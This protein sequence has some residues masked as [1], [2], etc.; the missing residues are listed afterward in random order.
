[1]SAP[2][3]YRKGMYAAAAADVPLCLVNVLSKRRFRRRIRHST[4]KFQR[5]NSPFCCRLGFCRKCRLTSVYILPLK[6]AGLKRK[7]Q[8][9]PVSD[10]FILTP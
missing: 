5:P 9:P 10:F 2:Q 4:K 3:I 1:M 8:V 7:E 6:Q